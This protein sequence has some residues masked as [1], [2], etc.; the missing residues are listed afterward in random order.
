[1]N[2]ILDTVEDRDAIHIIDE[3]VRRSIEQSVRPHHQRIKAK[4]DRAPT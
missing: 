1:M 2:D 3:S 4:C